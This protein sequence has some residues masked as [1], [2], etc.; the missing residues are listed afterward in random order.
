[1]SAWLDR[2]RR[3]TWADY[4]T[5]GEVFVVALIVEIALRVL[6]LLTI[7]RAIEWAFGSRRLDDPTAFDFDRFARFAAAPYRL[8]RRKGTCLRESLVFSVL[9]RRRGVPASIRFGVRRAEG[10]SWS[11]CP[12]W[13]GL[14]AH[15]WVDSPGIRSEVGS[16]FHELRGVW[17][18]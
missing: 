18:D 6:S 11:S 5:L 3:W 12:S 17:T 8:F 14:T 4:A 2:F 13:P 7:G 9:L 1:M 10:P 15:A 16:P